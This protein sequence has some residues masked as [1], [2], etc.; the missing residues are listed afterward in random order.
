MS[1][2]LWA[3]LGL[4]MSALELATGGFFLIFFGV[5]AL[6]VGVFTALNLHRTP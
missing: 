5:A 1:W 4:A 2:W 3:L 6:F